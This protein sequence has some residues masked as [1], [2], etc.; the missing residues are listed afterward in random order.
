MKAYIYH[1]RRGQY[2]ETGTLVAPT[3]THAM[4]RLR[5][6][7][8]RKIELREIVEPKVRHLRFYDS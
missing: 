5:Q 4:R 7:K 8:Y 6:R 1:A 3:R 2:R